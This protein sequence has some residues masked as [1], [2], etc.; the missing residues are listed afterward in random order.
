MVAI[1]FELPATFVQ[2]CEAIRRGEAPDEWELREDL[3]AY[4][5]PFR[6]PNLMLFTKV[7]RI[8]R[9]TCAMASEFRVEDGFEWSEEERRRPGFIQ[10]CTAVDKFVQFG[11]SDTGE[12]V[13]FDFGADPQEPSVVTWTHSDCYWRRIAPNF[14]TFMELFVPWGQGPDRSEETSWEDKGSVPPTPRYVLTFLARE[15]VLA[16][17]EGARPL[18]FQ[19]ADAYAKMSPEERREVEAELRED[20]GRM[21]LTPEQ[22]RTLDELWEKLRTSLPS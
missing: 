22:R 9:Q 13:C 12:P 15:D 6:I 10:D 20:L 8:A 16:T 18:F 1:G 5:H 7:D 19:L 17:E 21:G 2:L 3:D 11:K 4:G 14:T